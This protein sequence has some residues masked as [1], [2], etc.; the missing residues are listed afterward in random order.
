MILVVWA[1]GRADI[2]NSLQN[3]GQVRY[4]I[5]NLETE[6]ECGEQSRR[7]TN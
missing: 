5:L 2:V 3:K 4:G 7:G 1:L 6:D